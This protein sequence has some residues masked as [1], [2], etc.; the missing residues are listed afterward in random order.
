MDEHQ[1][2][3]PDE[4]GTSTPP[5]ASGDMPPAAPPSPGGGLPS[6]PAAG[7]E[8]GAPTQ[9]MGEPM[10]IGEPPKKNNTP[11]FVGIGVLAIAVIAA[12]AFF[13]LKKSGGGD[14]PETLGGV[15]RN[16]SAQAQQ[17]E[18]QAKQQS[19]AGMTITV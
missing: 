18:T 15:A 1:P 5:P 7:S 14:F 19:F 9:S 11:L 4:S 6:M 2:Q 17:I 13:A 12:V 8:W 3:T 10:P 16:H